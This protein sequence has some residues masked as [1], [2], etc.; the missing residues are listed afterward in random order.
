[1]GQ[2]TFSWKILHQTIITWVCSTFIDKNLIASFYHSCS[3]YTLNT[4]TTSVS[5]V[6]QKSDNKRVKKYLIK[7]MKAWKA[8]FQKN[9]IQVFNKTSIVEIGAELIIITP[10]HYSSSKSNFSW[11]G[12]CARTPTPSRTQTPSLRYSTIG[13]MPY[14]MTTAAR[15]CLST[16]SVL[17]L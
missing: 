5:E 4:L 2:N 12:N 8:K 3:T 15:L 1:M 9:N 10:P 11:N 7:R 16:G 6:L 14:Q 13:A 17:S